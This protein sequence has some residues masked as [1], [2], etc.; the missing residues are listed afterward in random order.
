MIELGFVS[1]NSGEVEG[2][3][4]GAA[5]R[6]AAP[7]MLQQGPFRSLLILFFSSLSPLFFSLSLL[8]LFSVC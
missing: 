7:V 3:G 5:R 4:G 2:M 8:L 1:S 6:R